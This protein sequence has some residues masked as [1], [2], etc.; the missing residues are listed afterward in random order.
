LVSC[1]AAVRPSS[2]DT[3]FSLRSEGYNVLLTSEWTDQTDDERNV[4]WT[5]QAFSAIEPFAMPSAYVNYFA[6]DES[7]GRVAAAYGA[8]YPRL[9]QIKKKYDPDN[10]FH[11]NQNIEP[12]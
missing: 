4:Q 5:K 1:G 7:A 3:P 8:N 6:D 9:R 10:V 12:A 2:S 11:L